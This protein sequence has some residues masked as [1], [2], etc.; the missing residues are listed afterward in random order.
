MLDDL[1]F[2]SMQPTLK[3]LVPS[4]ECEDLPSIVHYSC[5]IPH[6]LRMHTISF[7]PY[8]TTYLPCYGKSSLGIPSLR[9]PSTT[10]LSTL[11]THSL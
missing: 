6:H 7:S 10:S 2:M 4:S 1:C 9:N 5:F 11:T 3:T 8:Y